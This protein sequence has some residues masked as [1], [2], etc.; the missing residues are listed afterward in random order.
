MQFLFA[1]T[2]DFFFERS[3][4]EIDAAAEHRCGLFGQIQRRANGATVAEQSDLGMKTGRVF[5]EIVDDSFDRRLLNG[6]EQ[7]INIQS[8]LR[9]HQWTILREIDSVVDGR[10]HD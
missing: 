7:M 3:H 8:S 5:V 9:F 6:A 10:A 4:V 1:G 2:F